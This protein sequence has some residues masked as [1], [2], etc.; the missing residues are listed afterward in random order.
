MAS[1]VSSEQLASLLDQAAKGLRTLDQTNWA[2]WLECGRDLIVAGD[3]RGVTHTLSAF[4][5]MGSIND[6][7]LPNSGGAA[8]ETEAA[9]QRLLREI[10]S[11]ALELRREEG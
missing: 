7:P 1:T 4:G 9:V 3:F 10:H 11:V 8:F 6:R 5:G 2:S